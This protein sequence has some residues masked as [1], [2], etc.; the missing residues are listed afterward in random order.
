MNPLD[1]IRHELA[2][3]EGEAL[4]RALDPLPGVGGKLTLDGRAHLNFSSN[5]YLD[6]ALDAR[7]RD[8]AKRAVDDYGCGSTASR[9]MAGHLDLH[10]ALEAAIARLVRQEATL[11][12]PSGFQANLSV[13]TA[14]AEP[15]GAVFSDALN[16]ASIVDGCRL[17]KAAVHVYRHRDAAHLEELL[18]SVDAPGRKLI[19]TDSVF[20]MDG[21]TA[22]LTALRSLA[23]RYGALLIVDEAHGLG[24]FGEGRGLCA[25][26]GIAADVVVGA[27]AKA[28]GSAG[29]F[30]AGPE[31]VIQFLVN[32][33]R[34]FIFSSGLAP[35]CAASALEAV[36]IFETELGLGVELRR[37]A[38]ILRGGLRSRGVDVPDDDSQIVPVMLGSNAAALEAAHALR[39]RGILATAIRPPSVAEGT[40]RLRLSVTLA[41]TDADLERAA[42]A[43]ADAVI[44]LGAQSPA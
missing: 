12:F 31:P 21:D 9:L 41:H 15:G 32:K 14:L 38:N 4:L 6:L 19:V 10:A 13:L 37:R 25:E 27:M 20:S 23:E 30:V 24:V 17:A 44:S 8:A 3:L 18:Q 42:D 28:M 22:P 16:H 26:V 33:A 5:D 11:V 35:G 7:L 1:D 40:S 36:R 39:E 2:A 34:P 29:G 43:I